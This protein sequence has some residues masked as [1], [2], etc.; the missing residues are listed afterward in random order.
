MKALLVVALLGG[1]ASAET[2]K[3]PAGWTLDEAQSRALG[4]T[5]KQVPH[6]GL[7]APALANVDVYVAPKPG[8]VL[9]VSLVVASAK[10]ELDAAARV[11]VDELHAASQRAALAGSGISEDGW[12]EKVDTAAKQIE[13]TLAWRDTGAKASSTARLL[14]VAEPEH[15]V[16]ITGEC[17]ASD[18]ADAK[19]VGDCKAALATLDP[20]IAA[21]KR[22]PIGL[23]PTGARPS[24]PPDPVVGSGRE[25]ARLDD[26][27][28]APLPP[29]TL[30][31]EKRATDRRPVYVGLGLVGLAAVFWWNRRRRAREDES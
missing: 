25:P 28:R 1:I 4:A 26:G 2:V 11:A 21:D 20:G 7:A 27:S 5:L 23:A 9:T 31:A 29:M 14:V 22:L 16:S 3:A 17:F 10:T 30:P 13:A 12:Q 19:L 6:F 15:I 8:V 24:P 18:D